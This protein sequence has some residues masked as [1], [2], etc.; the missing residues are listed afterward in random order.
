MEQD[1]L[2]WNQVMFQHQLSDSVNSLGLSSISTMHCARCW[3][4]SC[5]QVKL[6]PLWSCRSSGGFEIKTINKYMYKYQLQMV[7]GTMKKCGA[8]KM[9]MC[10]RCWHTPVNTN[11]KVLYGSKREVEEDGETNLKT[12][13]CALP[14]PTFLEAT[15]GRPHV[16]EKHR[17][18]FQMRAGYPGKG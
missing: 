12:M 14:T 9:L 7:I 4:D 16:W 15:A 2:C 17:I 6:L 5:E 10:L 11:L 1:S 13:R 18:P 8:D 3:E